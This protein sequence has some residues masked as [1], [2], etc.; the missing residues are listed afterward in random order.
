M[1]QRHNQEDSEEQLIAKFKAI[2]VNER[3]DRLAHTS[4]KTISTQGSWSNREE[5]W[6]FV[7]KRLLFA[8]QSSSA[9]DTWVS[10]L[11]QLLLQVQESALRQQ[12]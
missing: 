7:N 6:Y 10:N 2:S 4:S 12:I 3:V 9:A 5:E 8:T 1:Q 11:S